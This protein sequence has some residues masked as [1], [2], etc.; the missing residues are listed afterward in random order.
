MRSTPPRSAAS[1]WR[2]A[3]TRTT[4]E[5]EPTMGRGDLKKVRAAR[6]RQRR[7]KDRARRVAVEKGKERKAAKR[8]YSSRTVRA[9]MLGADIPEHA[10]P[11]PAASSRRFLLACARD[12][13]VGHL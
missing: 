5:S 13:P 3:A 4:T 12:H 8:R 1:S 7:V 2:R 6:D 10:K 9:R 11:R